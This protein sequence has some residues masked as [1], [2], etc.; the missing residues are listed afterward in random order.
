MWLCRYS[1]IASL[2]FGSP[3]VGRGHYL[4]CAK[5]GKHDPHRQLERGR[6]LR[7]SQRMFAVKEALLMNLCPSRHHENP[8]TPMPSPW[9]TLLVIICS[10]AMAPWQFPSTFAQQAFTGTISD[11]YS[12]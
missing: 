2:S 7:L 3:R 11:Y 10:P 12:I 4:P 6:C 1:M 9:N 8:V 5:R